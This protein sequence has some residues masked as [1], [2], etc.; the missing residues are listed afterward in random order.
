MTF[1]VKD[2]AR[3]ELMQVSAEVSIR[4]HLPIDSYIVLS[5]IAR[6]FLTDAQSLHQLIASLL[7]GCPPNPGSRRS[8]WALFNDNRAKRATEVGGIPP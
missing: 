6:G 4:S 7:W 1:D 5:T 2:E 8:G 3:D